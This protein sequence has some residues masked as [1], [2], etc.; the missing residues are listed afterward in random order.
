MFAKDKQFSSFVSSGSMPKKK[1][2]CNIKPPE[3]H[4][5]DSHVRLVQTRLGLFPDDIVSLTSVY[6]NFFISSS[7]VQRQNKQEWLQVEI[8]QPSPIRPYKALNLLILGF[9]FYF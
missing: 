9:L 6:Q 1:E 2:V 8:F 7:L 5:L 3:G 4:N